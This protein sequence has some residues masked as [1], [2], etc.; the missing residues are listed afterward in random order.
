MLRQADHSSRAILH[1]V[2]HRF[3]WYR[4]VMNEV[5]VAQ[6]GPR[7]QK[8]NYAYKSIVVYYFNCV[9]VVADILTNF[10]YFNESN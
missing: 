6:V 9:V 1:I 3:V 4:K 5:A 8:E 7:G 2:I 10:A